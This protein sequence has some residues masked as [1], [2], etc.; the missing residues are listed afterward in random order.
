MTKFDWVFIDLETTGIQSETDRIIEV[1]AISVKSDGTRET[2]QQMVNPGIPIPEFITQLTGISD[3]MVKNAP[4]MSEILPLLLCF[5]E[6]KVLVAHN[7]AFD[8]SFLRAANGGKL[9]NLH[10]CTFEL[11][12]LLFPGLSSYSLQNLVRT[13]EI[14]EARPEHRALADTL[15]LEGLFAKLMK[16]L[17]SLSIKNLEEVN[18]FFQDQEK[19]LTF[20]WQEVLREKV[21]EYNFTEDTKASSYKDKEV[22]DIKEKKDSG[23]EKIWDIDY[24]IKMF[25]PGGKIALAFQTYQERPAQ[26]KLLKSVAKAFM[27]RRHLLAEA[28]TG[29]GKSLA[30]LVPAVYW[31]VTE[32][33]KVVISTHTIALQEQLLQSDIKFLK[34]E[35]RI[36]LHA[37][38]FKGRSNYV[39]RQRYQA[40]KENAKTMSWIEKLFFARVGLWLTSNETG[41]KDSLNLGEW[42]H[43][44][45][46]QLASSS[47]N[48]HSHDCPYYQAC[49]YQKARQHAQDA[50]V[51]IINHSL[52]L[53][54]LKLG[55][56]V[57]PPYKYLVID[58]A[59]HLEEEGSKQFSEVFS[60]RNY[61]RCLTGLARKRDIF[62]NKGV[63]F[64]WKQYFIAENRKDDNSVSMVQMIEK[65]ETIIGKLQERLK[66]IINYTAA[67]TSDT[68]RIKAEMKENQYWK[69]ISLLFDNFMVINADLLETLKVIQT[70]IE[71]EN[72]EL[73]NLYN[74]LVA[75]YHL[76]REFF[77]D[78]Q[79]DNMVYWMEKAKNDL[80]LYITPVKTA[81]IF[82]EKLFGEK[83][84]VIMTSATLSI[85][86]RFSFLLEQ[87][88]I[89]EDIVDTVSIDSPFLYDEQS[90]LLVDRS[91]PDPV[92]TSEECY[93]LALGDALKT[94]LC[95][96]KGGTMV[97]FTSHKQMRSIYNML[98][99][100]LKQAGLELLVDGINGS[101]N[102]LLREIKNNPFVVVFGANTFWEGIDLP[103]QA[104]TALVIV[105]LPFLPPNLPLVEAKIEQLNREG[106]N[107]FY[108]YSLPQAVVRFKQGYGRLI[109]SID[110]SGVVVVMD[111]RIVEKKYGKVFLRSLPCSNFFV[112]ETDDIACRIENWFSE[113]N[114]HK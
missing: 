68:I 47:D 77:C 11:A 108:S 59:H 45:Y 7:A 82:N 54:D 84:S 29:V 55:G 36:P 50:D 111:R 75:D 37:A 70:G 71:G 21:R 64:S 23:F 61:S 74:S 110:D 44:I 1:A 3:D 103:G 41:D 106:K 4:R 76:V 112:G 80:R 15:A 28:G 81:D 35:L 78:I 25:L 16:R 73:H 63:L 69:E 98:K 96:T 114:I 102:V 49:F 58:E 62:R 13:F 97:L 65:A 34:E 53:T 104:L 17:K 26:I 33:E 27:Q 20:L 10:V 6:G 46:H 85:E 89:D 95:A 19:G 8:L 39:C 22:K 93:N 66:E 92:K 31:S 14:P 105:K 72:Y 2:Y 42:E 43:E 90:L 12:R 79:D 24:L 57:L 83:E 86:G 99:E 52:L 94:L 51:L 91:L 107:G 48:C 113:M 109:R 88:G 32:G 56:K 101:R 87:L 9:P 38:V 100:P 18:H 60:L 30:Y 67:M 5:I 40:A